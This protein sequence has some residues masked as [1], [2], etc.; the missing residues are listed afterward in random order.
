MLRVKLRWSGFQGAPGYSIFHFRDFGAPE[1]WDPTLAQAQECVA[2][3]KVFADA[4]GLNTI[5]GGVQLAVQSEVEEIEDTTGALVGI[6]STTPVAAYTSGIAAAPFSAAT[7]AVINWRTN[8]VRR[9][10]RI[11]GRTFIVPVKG[12]A[13][14]NDGTLA[15]AT[16]SGINSAATTF[17]ADGSSPDLGVYARPTPI[18]DAEG[19]PTGEYLPDGQWAP[20]ASFNVPDLGAVLRSRRD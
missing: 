2:K 1:G 3:T 5:P 17:A 6:F 13:M 16:I 14:D 15:A 19:K 9:N 12:A 7:G 11:R 18:L 10:R 8:T 4:I 20:V